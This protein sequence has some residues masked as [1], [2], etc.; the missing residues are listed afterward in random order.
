MVKNRP[1]YFICH[2]SVDFMSCS[3]RHFH[4]AVHEKEDVPYIA[5]NL[6]KGKSISK[7]HREIYPSLLHC[8]YTSLST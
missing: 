8:T 7:H 1:R 5:A 2:L 6:T 3:T 4:Q